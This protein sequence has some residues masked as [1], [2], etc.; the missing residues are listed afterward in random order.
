MHF[1][2]GDITI[3]YLYDTTKIGL[4]FLLKITELSNP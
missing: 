2:H 4:W 3:P 1:N